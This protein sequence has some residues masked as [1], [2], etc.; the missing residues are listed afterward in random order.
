MRAHYGYED[1]SGRYYITVDTELCTGCE[2]CVKICPA[3]VLEVIEEDPIEERLVAAVAEPH[4]K[5]IKYS[6]NPCKPTGYGSLP[7]VAVCEPRTLEHSW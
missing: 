3:G 5:K 1:G 4:R 2:E 7:C 6:C